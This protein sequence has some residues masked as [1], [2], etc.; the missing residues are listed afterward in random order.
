ML[1]YLYIV[2]LCVYLFLNWVAMKKFLALFLCVFLLWA[3]VNAQWSYKLSDSK[4][5]VINYNSLER[6][7]NNSESKQYGAKM[8]KRINSLIWIY[9]KNWDSAFK[10]WNYDLAI[11]NYELA[12]NK[13]KGIRWAE[14]FI[15]KIEQRIDE[16]KKLNPVSQKGKIKPVVNNKSRSSNT[17]RKYPTT[18]G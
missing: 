10:N 1:L 17:S 15:R 18:R 3:I 5:N 2:Y 11:K 8:M 14:Y 9:L 16:I 6:L 12:I 7:V 4:K 13:L